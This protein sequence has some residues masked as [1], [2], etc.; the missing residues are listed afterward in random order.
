MINTFPL[1]IISNKF[2]TFFVVVISFYIS[3]VV[4]DIDRANAELPIMLKYKHETASPLN[5]R[6][7]PFKSAFDL[8]DRKL[9]DSD[10]GVM[11]ISKNLDKDDNYTIEKEKN[12]PV[13]SEIKSET[14]KYGQ[15]LKLLYLFQLV[16]KNKN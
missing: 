5:V 7:P 8:I 11:Y 1:R 3:D 12:D 2:S 15:V 6:D 4:A 13:V 10:N 9:L 16:K 14:T